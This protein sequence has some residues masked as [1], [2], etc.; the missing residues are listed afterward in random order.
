MKLLICIVAAIAAPALPMTGSVARTASAASTP[1]ASAPARLPLGP[2]TW[3]R[4]ETPN[5]TVHGQVGEARLRSIITRLEAFRAALEW[6]QPGARSSPRETTVFVFKDAATGIP[7]SPPAAAG[8]HHLGA[9]AAFD[10]RNYVTIA[11]PMDDPPLDLLYHAYAHQ[12]LD[13]NYPRLPLTLTEG[14][15]EFY[16]GFAVTSAETLIGVPHPDHLSWLKAHGLPSLS[17]QFSIDPHGSQLSSP[18]DWTG[19]LASSWAVAHYLVSTSGENSA[20]LLALMASMQRGAFPQ[21]AMVSDYGMSLEQLQQEV[22]RYLE[23][24]A[25]L[26]LAVRGALPAPSDAPGAPA[27]TEARQAGPD[28]GTVTIDP[29]TKDEV[30]AALGELLAHSG[31][32]R[33]AEAEAYLRE[34]LRLNPERGTAYSGL[35]YLRY[36]ENRFDEAVPQLEKAV[37]I[38]PDAMSCYLLAR[39][40]LRVNAGAGPAT[41]GARDVATDGAT[42]GT[43]GNQ[44]PPWLGRVRILLERAI[45]LR[46]QF[47]AAYVTLGATHI[48]PD[49]DVKAGIDMLQRARAMLPARMDI[50][51]D[52]V[53]LFLRKEDLAQAQRLVDDVLVT[54]G[55][56]PVLEAAQRA[57][58]TY[59]GNVQAKR[60]L[61]KNHATPEDEARAE[62]YRVAML[63]R[64]REALDQTTDPKQRTRLEEAIKTYDHA[65]S[66]YDG[67]KGVEIFNQAIDYANHRDYPKAIATLEDLQLKVREPDLSERIKIMLE[68]FRQDAARLQQSIK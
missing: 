25:F 53:Y 13:D 16:S 65:I 11:A 59:R 60:E 27:A 68:R 48:F 8:G 23:R 30:V 39:S 2:E 29:M 61:E 51:G 15:A 38:E 46:P 36:L 24:R 32:K 66:F 9:T 43:T 63:K 67:N 6:L 33:A 20:R 22:G 19:F 31:P 34:A 47:A 17:V 54:G 50:V 57:I 18:S 5:F 42:G 35:G 4:A 10:Q 52:L 58:V 40:L 49:G 41:G 14:L 21:A 28:Q 26:P 64:L 1:A 62:A 7:Y 3:L 56:Q 12:F 44:T 55:D 37:E 45:L